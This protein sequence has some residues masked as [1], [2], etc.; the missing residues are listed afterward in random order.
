MILNE[1]KP[2]KSIGTPVATAPHLSND[3]TQPNAQGRVASPWPPPSLTKYPGRVCDL[4]GQRRLA[5]GHAAAQKSRA[6]W[7]ACS[8]LR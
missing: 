8:A 4:I 3:A 1:A 7:R 5:G 6:A 2:A